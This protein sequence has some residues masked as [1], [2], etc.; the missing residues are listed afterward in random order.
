VRELADK[1]AVR[2]RTRAADIARALA[3]DTKRRHERYGDSVYLLEPDVKLGAG[4]MRDL[5]VARWMLAPLARAGEDPLGVL[6]AGGALD[7]RELE[8]AL[9]A[10]AFSWRVRNRLHA[11]AGRRSDRLTFDAQEALAAQ[12]GYGSSSE[13]TERFMQDHYVH[14]RAISRVHDRATSFATRKQRGSRGRAKAVEPGLVLAGGAVAFADSDLLE[15]DPAAALRAYAACVRLGAPLD[16]A[17]RDAIAR[18]TTVPER[19]SALRA[20]AEAAALFVGLISEMPR[21]LHDV[22]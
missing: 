13:A 5:E 20:S 9:A 18:M 19:C 7:A 16:D 15:R 14:A 21:E 2:A 1:F 10:E 8:A 12:L 4:G 3:E 6:V 22:G 11:L 17:A